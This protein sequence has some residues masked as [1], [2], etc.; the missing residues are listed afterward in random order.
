MLENMQQLGKRKMDESFINT[1]IEYLSEFDINEDGKQ[2][3]LRWCGGT[4][5]QVSDNTWVKPGCR[6]KCYKTH[7]A[8]FVHWDAV[9][10]ADLPSTRSIEP[11]DEKKWNGNCSGSWRKELSDVNYGV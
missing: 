1:R 10:E 6:R 4:V 7:E 8:A 5:E 2:K 11:F 3:E 9:P